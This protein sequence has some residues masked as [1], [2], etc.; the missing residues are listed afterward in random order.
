M[1]GLHAA[2]RDWPVDAKPIGAEEQSR[3]DPKSTF[4]LGEIGTDS[5]VSHWRINVIRG[6]N[7]D[8]ACAT[9]MD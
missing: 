5:Q 6:Q 4:I 3:F 1:L 9:Q 2:K 7:G 8:D